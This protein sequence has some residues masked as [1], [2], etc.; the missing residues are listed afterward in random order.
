MAVVAAAGDQA[1]GR[2]QPDIPAAA[3]GGQ[4]FV[5]TVAIT[6]DRMVIARRTGRA[7]QM[8]RVWPG[9]DRDDSGLL[10]EQRH[11]LRGRELRVHQAEDDEGRQQDERGAERGVR[12]QEVLDA[13]ADRPV[14]SSELCRRRR[15]GRGFS[16][17]FHLV[18]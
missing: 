14:A 1:Q 7:G 9:Q 10:H 15:R 12:V 18:S 16:P 2:R 8:M 17:S 3:P 6:V 11:R 4:S 13:L 5:A